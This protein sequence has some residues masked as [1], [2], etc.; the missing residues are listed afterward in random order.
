MDRAAGG[1]PA[2]ER[3]SPQAAAAPPA[4]AA[5]GGQGGPA[6]RSLEEDWEQ[7]G[8]EVTALAIIYSQHFQLLRPC[9]LKELPELARVAEE[10]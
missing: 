4:G 8:D 3:G 6:Q 1:H 10:R 9:S 7:V 2:L 5:P